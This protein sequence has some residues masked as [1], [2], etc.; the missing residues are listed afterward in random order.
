MEIEG[1]K[2]TSLYTA[3]LHGIKL[4]EHKIRIKLDKYPLAGQ[5]NNYLTKI[6]NAYFVYDLNAYP[7]DP[8]NSFKSENGPL[9]Y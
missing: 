7:R 5:Q 3:P 6:V 9:G 4:F 8:T 2:L 1:S